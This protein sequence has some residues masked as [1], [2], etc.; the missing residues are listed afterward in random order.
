MSNSNHTNPEK[1]FEET[2]EVKIIFGAHNSI[3]FKGICQSNDRFCNVI[4]K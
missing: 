3:H 4:K 2:M 1:C